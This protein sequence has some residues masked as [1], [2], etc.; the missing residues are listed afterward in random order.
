[1]RTAAQI[2]Q[3][4]FDITEYNGERRYSDSVDGLDDLGEE[5]R[6]TRTTYR[7]VGTRQR[8]TGYED[9][10]SIDW[11]QEITRE[12]RR[13]L[14]LEEDQT[15]NGK[16]IRFLDKT[17]IWVILVA[18]GIAVGVLAASIDVVSLYLGDLK[19]GY[20]STSF[21]LSKSFCCWGLGEDDICHDWLKWS[22]ALN[23]Y[24]KGGGY[25]VNYLLYVLY[26]AALAA[27]ASTLVSNYAPYAS[28]SGIPEIKIMLSG[29]VIKRFLGKMTLLVKSLG[30]CLAVSSGLWLGKEGPL[31]HVAACCG[32][33]ILKFFPS[34]A[35]NEARKREIF[36]AASAAGM[37]VAF[38]SPIGGVLFSLE[39]ISY[40]FPDRIL[41]HA[42]VCAM[43]SSVSIQFMNPFRTGKLVLYQVVFDRDWKNF[44]LIPFILLGV[45]GGLYGVFFI[46]LNRL[47]EQTR[48][49]TWISN[50]P[51][52]EV[53][54]LAFLTALISFPNVFTRIPASRVLT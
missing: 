40:Y 41:W 50:Y 36:S 17:Q 18:T 42:F 53:A 7:S 9:L 14:I 24:S 25:I 10:A 35:G 39:Q 3:E 45:I 11:I 21:Y 19:E 8:D 33:V 49:S 15:V 44:E 29:V 38:G 51:T 48:K 13:R 34:V 2:P 27:S 23:T 31:V 47:I 6:L 46:R 52:S 43:I 1:M 4:D 28:H 16:T 12:R 26:A 54:V 22:D 37:S 20:C 5:E 32:S 30:L